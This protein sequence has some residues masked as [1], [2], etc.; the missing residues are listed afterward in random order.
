M[1]AIGKKI[2]K[3]INRSQSEWKNGIMHKKVIPLSE[4]S[5]WST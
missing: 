5:R 2:L 4:K 3:S 1:N